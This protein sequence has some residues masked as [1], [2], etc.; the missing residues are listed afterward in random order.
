MSMYGPPGGPYPGQPQDPWQ[1]GQQ[2]HDPYGQGGGDP[3]GQQ[4]WG[5]P[6]PWGGS[7][8]SGPL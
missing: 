1:G 2:P 7:P 5:Q 8:A 6:D 3:Y 4:S